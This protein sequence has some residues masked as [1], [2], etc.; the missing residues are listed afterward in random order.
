MDNVL[1]IGAGGH[2]KSVIAFLNHQKGLNIIGLVEKDGAPCGGM[3]LGVP[4]IGTDSQ[5]QLLSDSGYHNALITL[6][7]VG[8]NVPRK[9]LYNLAKSVGFE[10]VNAFHP[11]STVSEYANIGKGVTVLAQAVVG[12]DTRIGNNVI[13]NSGAIIEHDCNVGDHVHLAPGA[14]IAG[15]VSIGADSHIGI[16][17]VV[18]Q[19]LRIGVNA[20]IGA[21]AVVNRD[22]PEG[23]VVMGVPG[24]VTRYR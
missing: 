8:N 10:F 17:A 18:L 22:V 13:I 14:K 19:G 24:K 11:D 9:R 21:G 3:I 7:S 12:P 23:A 15:G 1:L 16:G 5:L 20:L 6:G 2:A 4:V